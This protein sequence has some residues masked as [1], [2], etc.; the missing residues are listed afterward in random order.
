V[1]NHVQGIVNGM[2]ALIQ[3]ARLQLQ[4]VVVCSLLARRRNL[5]WRHWGKY[6]QMQQT[7]WKTECVIGFTVTC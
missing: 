1:N 3:T 7:H 4:R 2:H 6:G 5:A